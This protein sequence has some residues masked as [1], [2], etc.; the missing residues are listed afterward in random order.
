MTCYTLLQNN[1]R[2]TPCFS[3]ELIDVSGNYG[4]GAIKYRHLQHHADRSH[5]RARKHACDRAFCSILNPDTDPMRHTHPPRPLTRLI[6]ATSLALVAA[7]TTA[8]AQTTPPAAPANEPTPEARKAAPTKSAPNAPATTTVPAKPAAGS[9]TPRTENIEVNQRRTATSE[10]RDSSASKIIIT[11]EDIEQ[12]GDSNLGEVMRRLPGVTTGGRPG[13]QGGPSMRGMGGGFTQILINGERVSPGFSIEQITPEMVERIEIQRAP[14]AET[15]TRAVAGTINVVLREPLRQRNNDL[16]AAL[17][18]ER[19]KYSPNLAWSRNDTIGPTGTYNLTISLNGSNQLT[20]TGTTTTYVD[21]PSRRVNLAQAGFNQS[22]EKRNSVFATSRFQWRLGQGEMFS[23]QPFM[24]RNK[25]T[26]TTNA[27]LSQSIGATPAPYATAVGQVDGTFNMARAMLMLNKRLNADLRMELRGGLSQHK[28]DSDSIL[29][30]RSTSG[31]TVL[32]QSTDSNTKDNSW[33][34]VGKLMY[35]WLD[36]KHNL[37]TG[38]EYEAVKRTDNSVTLLNGAPLLTN[39]GDQIEVATTRKALYVQNEWDPHPQF[40]TYLGLR[41]EGIETKSR[42]LTNPVRNTSSVVNPLA[43]GVWRFAAPRR[44]QIRVSLTQS[45]R[46]PSTQNLVG[47]PI[48]N[49]L[50]PVPGANTSVSPDRAGNPRLKPE[51]A[52]GVDIAYE[53]YLEGGGVVSVNLFSR[54]INDLIRNVTSL[55][56]VTWASSPRFVTR[57]QNLGKARTSGIEFDTRF[58]L[59]EIFKDAPAINFRANLSVFDSKVDS[60]PGPNNRIAEQPKMTGNFGADYRFR[61]TPFSIGGNIN[62]TPDFETRLTSNQVTKTGTKRVLEAYGLWTIDSQMKLRLS[63]SNLSPRDAVNTS[64]FT[65]GNELQ[66]ITSNGK[67]A[68]S[69]ALRLEIRL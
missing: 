53:N 43:H 69:T 40:S 5:P 8:G 11:R 60:V 59:P 6:A 23:I 47:R 48:L 30:E 46:A 39:F 20:D 32:T 51:L 66:T 64:S 12:Y 62:F 50:F 1:L 31:A 41:W 13:R 29:R 3:A 28:S 27:T 21:V 55:E 49:T 10:R 57:P 38:W 35:N 42:T 37:V 17:Q 9:A 22:E 52:N 67:T 33:N 58:R 63:F 7:T 16:R 18:E 65:Q 14:T 4:G 36:G 15:G 19:G 44:D 54:N 56:T 34:M 68:M 25:F 26:N 45:Y 2:N 61:A 24:V